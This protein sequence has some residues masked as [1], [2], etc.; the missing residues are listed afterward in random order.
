M[1]G[2]LHLEFLDMEIVVSG[3]VYTWGKGENGQL[4]LGDTQNRY[5]PSFVEALDRQAPSATNYDVGSTTWV[6]LRKAPL[7]SAMEVTILGHGPSGSPIDPIQRLKDGKECN[8]WLQE[9][10]FHRRD[11]IEE[12]SYAGNPKRNRQNPVR[13]EC[14]MKL[15]NRALR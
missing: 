6:D 15:W 2:D 8:A 4:G 1:Y 13:C 10:K 7:L 11:Q 3:S 14:W 12:E 5:M 9:C